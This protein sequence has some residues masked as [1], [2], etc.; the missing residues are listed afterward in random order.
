MLSVLVGLERLELLEAQATEVTRQVVV[1]RGDA[2]AAL[3]VCQDSGER[4][5]RDR[6]RCVDARGVVSVPQLRLP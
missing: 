1:R 6:A 3:M 4:E 5:K 2:H